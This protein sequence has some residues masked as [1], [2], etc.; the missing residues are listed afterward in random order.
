MKLSIDT[1]GIFKSDV[2]IE[3][4]ELKSE[5]VDLKKE[6]NESVTRNPKCF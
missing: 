3:N 2:A 4:A 1:F 5:I 6:K